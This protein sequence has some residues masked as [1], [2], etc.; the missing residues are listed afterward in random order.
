MD[1]LDRREV[2]PARRRRFKEAPEWCSIFCLLRDVAEQAARL[3]ERAEELGVEIVAFG[4]HDDGGVLERR[5][6]NQ[7]ARIEQHREAL[8]ATLRVPDDA[9][10][11]VALLFGHAT[12]LL[13]RAANGVELVIA[14]ELF[15][16]LA[17][18]HLERDKAG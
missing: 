3:C 14:R 11:A 4:D 18:F 15:D 13:D 16:Q 6:P 9:N 7:L 10:L 2:H 17:P 5:D 8:A 1:H 12:G